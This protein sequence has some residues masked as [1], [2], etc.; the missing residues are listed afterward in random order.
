MKLG[1][2]SV[3]P[4]FVHFRRGYML[5]ASALI[6]RIMSNSG[7][8]NI[9]IP[10]PIVF[11]MIH[12]PVTVPYRVKDSAWTMEIGEHS[13]TALKQHP[14]ALP[15]G[16]VRPIFIL[17]MKIKRGQRL[18]SLAPNPW[19]GFGPVKAGMSHESNLECI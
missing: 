12:A 1:I 3:A 17:S 14:W 4:H 15:H 16:M 10:Y 11:R 5:I 2:L 13:V 8:S 7:L 19:A 18:P 9:G 6:L